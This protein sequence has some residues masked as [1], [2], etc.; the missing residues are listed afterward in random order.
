M[1]QNGGLKQQKCT[2]LQFRR[3]TSETKAWAGFV[4]P[5]ASLLGLETAVFSLSSHGLWACASLGVSF[6]YKDTSHNGLG[7]TLMICFKFTS[8]KTVSPNT[9]TLGG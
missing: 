8:L 1:S 3:L 2:L 4:F 5:E 6:S 9:V 7:P